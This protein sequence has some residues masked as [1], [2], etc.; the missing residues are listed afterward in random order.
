MGA[1]TRHVRG[2]VGRTA[3]VALAAFALASLSGC[4]GGPGGP[5]SGG[6]FLSGATGWFGG[7][8]KIAIAP[9]IGTT[10]EV[11]AAIDR[12]PGCRRQGAQAHAAP[13]RR[14][15]QLHV[16]RLSRRLERKA[17]LENLLYLGCHRRPGLARDARLRRRGR[18]RLAPAAIPGAASTAPR[19][20]ASP[21]RPPRNSPQACRGVGG[22]ASA[23]ATA[24]PSSGT[25]SGITPARTTR[26]AGSA[27]APQ[28]RSAP[29]PPACSFSPC[30]ARPAT[31]R[32]P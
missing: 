17:R 3:S 22:S 18:S 24:S 11:A 14:Q 21:A 7:S 1:D 16:A 15:G 31:G 28:R 30:P 25:S 5:S 12:R 2:W 29:N 8:T 6:G 32:G 10:P 13:R 9:I 27:T 26:L 4:G 20:A 19:S 23:V